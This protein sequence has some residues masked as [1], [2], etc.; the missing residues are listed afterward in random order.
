LIAGVAHEINTPLGAINSSIRNIA[1]FWQQN[2]PEIIQ[3]T[4][5]IPDQ[6]RQ[7]FLNL[8]EAIDQ[9][10][11][12]LSTREERQIKKQLT[13]ELEQL[14][15]AK[16]SQ[17]AN[18]LIGLGVYQTWQNWQSVLTNEYGENILQNAYSLA[19]VY[20]STRTIV[21]ATERAAKI[22]FA[23]KSYAHYDNSGQPMMA[24]VI[25]GIETILTLYYNQMK[26][27]VNLIRN[28][29]GNLP[30]ILC[31]PDELNQVWT[32]LIHNAL[33]AMNYH[34]NLTINVDL[35]AENIMISISDTGSGIPAD[36]LPQI[37]EPFFTT[38]LPGEG[39]G[40]GLDIVRKII[41]KHRGKIL[42]NSQPGETTFT[43]YLP[44]SANTS[45]SI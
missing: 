37:F 15:L 2:F 32:N 30:Q 42:V 12:N 44:Q 29:H 10:P 31:Y 3:F 41:E 8:V 6:P 4:Q 20:R 25:D 27:G 21:T 26:H 38:K 13:K 22:V 5:T 19:N 24:Q 16:P 28:Y 14:N 9:T 1:N 36:I 39:S 17:I 23:L 18:Y 7:D 40:L 45:Y 35:Q 11:E 43:I 34:G 33:Q